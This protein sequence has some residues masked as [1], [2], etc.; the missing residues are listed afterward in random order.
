MY[1]QGACSLVQPSSN[2]C[3]WYGH[4]DTTTQDPA[5]TCASRRGA[6]RT[7]K[8]SPTVRRNERQQQPTTQGRPGPRGTDTAASS[9][10]VSEN[11]FP[12]DMKVVAPALDDAISSQSSTLTRDECL[13]VLENVRR[14]VQDK[15]KVTE[16]SLLQE[17]NVTPYKMH[18]V[19]TLL[20]FASGSS[21]TEGH[22]KWMPLATMMLHQA[23]TVAGAPGGVYMPSILTILH[24]FGVDSPDK[25]QSYLDASARIRRSYLSQNAEK[26]FLSYLERENSVSKSS[27]LTDAELVTKANAF[28]LAGMLARASG[29]LPRAL[30]WYNAAWEVGWEIKAMRGEGPR[31]TS[32]SMEAIVTRPPLWDWERQCLESLGELQ[33]DEVLAAEPRS[34]T[35]KQRNMQRYNDAILALVTAGMALGSGKAGMYLDEKDVFGQTGRSEQKSRMLDALLLCAVMSLEPGAAALVAKREADK[36]QTAESKSEIAYQ[37]LVADEWQ[38]LSAAASAGSRTTQA[39]LSR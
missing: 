13:E 3:P 18:M 15:I 28:T 23:A 1:R 38:R 31:D 7:S 26:H 9:A 17:Y 4:D 39:W 25:P 27:A 33:L 24:M 2:F 5:I 37:G 11:I 10:L 32:D 8:R 30:R 35:E 16:S 22:T 21:S 36:V 12:S 6:A 14:I 19:A 34:A 29:Q 20:L